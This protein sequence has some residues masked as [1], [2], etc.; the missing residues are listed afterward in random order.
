MPLIVG[1]RL[2]LDRESHA[3]WRDRHRVDVPTAR[4]TQGVT[5][6]PT[7]LPEGRQNPPDLIL[8]ASSHPAALSEGQPV[9]GSKAEDHRE[10]QER[11][12]ERAGT[13]PQRG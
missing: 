6:P 11:S 5:Q 3:S 1:P 9:A 8:G 12:T 10:G 7:S 13:L 4:P 2:R